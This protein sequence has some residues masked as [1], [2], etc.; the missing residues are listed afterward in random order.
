MDNGR[1]T[2]YKPEFDDM[3]YKLALLGLV[4]EQMA[5]VFDICVATLNN[6][7]RE[8]PSFLSSIKK[9]KAPADAEVA[10]SLNK[11]ALGYEYDEITDDE[12]NGRKIVRK[13]VPAD[14]TSVIFWLKNRQPKVWRDKQEVQVDSHNVNENITS[15]AELIMNPVKDREIPEE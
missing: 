9:G 14:P 10:M 2:K 5:D 3:A 15:L 12:K 8:H 1:P 7:K 11:R 4:D 6:W 13:H